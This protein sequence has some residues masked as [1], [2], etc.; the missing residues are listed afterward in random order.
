MRFHHFFWRRIRLRLLRHCFLHVRQCTRPAVPED[1][2]PQ[3]RSVE[4]TRRSWRADALLR[5]RQVRPSH[6]P[7][8]AVL[9]AL[10]NRQGPVE[11][12]PRIAGT[13]NS[14]QRFPRAQE[15]SC[16]FKWN[17]AGFPQCGEG[18]SKQALRLVRIRRQN[19]LRPVGGRASICQPGL[20]CSLVEPVDNL[21]T[22]VGFSSAC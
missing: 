10:E 19:S 9:P 15:R 3:G 11:W 22:A 16:F 4:S 13:A 20:V 12:Q 5:L 14:A 8:K 2:G 7:S 18:C 6:E 17:W 21:V 1:L